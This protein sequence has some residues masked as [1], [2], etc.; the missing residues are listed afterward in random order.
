MLGFCVGWTIFTTI[1]VSPERYRKIK[2]EREVF[3]KVFIWN[4]EA[5]LSL[6]KIMKQLL[7]GMFFVWSGLP[8][9]WA[10]LLSLAILARFGSSFTE[11]SELWKGLLWWISPGCIL[12]ISLFLQFSFA[13]SN[14]I[15]KN[16]DNRFNSCVFLVIWAI[17]FLP[18][19]GHNNTDVFLTYVCFM[20]W[21]GMGFH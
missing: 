18:W 3:A 6:P 11:H 4:K 21:F 5:L 17:G 9:M 15:G 12:S 16:W 20:V 1:R 10:I 7:V 2:K 13:H 14:W 19:N 8:L